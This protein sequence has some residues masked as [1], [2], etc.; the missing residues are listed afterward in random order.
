MAVGVL[1]A[2]V[3]TGIVWFVWHMQTG[4]VAAYYEWSAT[5]MIVA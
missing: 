2:A 4:V 3:V 5:E 1:A